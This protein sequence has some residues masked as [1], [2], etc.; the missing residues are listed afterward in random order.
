DLVARKPASLTFEQ[1]ASVPLAANTALQGLRDVGR[2]Q[3]GQ[4]VLINGASG[5]VG[6]YAVQI[7][8][9]FGAEVTGVCGTK[10]VDLVRSL[11]ADHVVD[12]TQEDFSRSGRRHDIVFDLVA[13]RSLSA[14]RRALTPKGT[15]VL[16]GG[17]GGRWIGPVGLI[18]RAVALSP[19][20]GQRLAPLTEKQSTDD[21]DFLRGLIE[22]GKV[23]PVIDRTYSLSDAPEAI[24]Y[25]YT[26]RTRGKV[27]IT[28]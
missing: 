12:Y 15:L 9:S 3:A 20:A 18:G 28:V 10:N 22:A 1:A 27:V 13:N 19:F 14:L 4:T 2:I 7:A 11:G 17:G 5:G 24:G 25:V 23:T 16:S 21:L 26:G 6:T 8:K